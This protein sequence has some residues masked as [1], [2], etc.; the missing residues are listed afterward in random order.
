MTRPSVKVSTALSRTRRVASVLRNGL[1]ES[2]SAKA[3]V[4]SSI[5]ALPGIPTWPSFFNA[6]SAERIVDQH[7]RIRLVTANNVFAH[8][9][10]L[11]GMADAVRACLDPDGAFVFQVSYLVDVVSHLEVHDL[12]GKLL[13]EI[14]LPTK[15]ASSTLVIRMRYGEY[16]TR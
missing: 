10:D 6:D 11:G 5:P 4:P 16:V 8:A 2:R 7:G 12:E 3:C 15:G 1:D 13:R 9:D 14:P